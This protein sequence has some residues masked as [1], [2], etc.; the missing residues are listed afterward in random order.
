MKRFLQSRFGLILFHSFVFSLIYNFTFFKKAAG[1]YSESENVFFLI[2]L[3][4]VLFFVI[5]IFFSLFSF[6]TRLFKLWVGFNYIVSAM[7]LYSMYAYNVVVDNVMILNLFDSNKNELL[8]LISVQ[9]I[10]VIF[11]L[12]ITP[13]VFVVFS[14]IQDIGFRRYFVRAIGL[15]CLCIVLIFGNLKTF[16]KS[17]ASFFRKHKSIRSYIL[18]IFPLYSIGKLLSQK[19]KKE[20]PYVD[21]ATDVSQLLDK[22]NILFIVIGE[23]VR[24]DHLSINGY[25]KKTTPKLANENIITYSNVTSC[26]TSTAYSVPCLFSPKNMDEFKLDEFSSYSNLLDILKKLP[27]TKVVWRDN[28]SDSK[29]VAKRIGSTDYRSRKLNPI[30]NEEC[31]D[32]GMLEGIEKLYD[33]ET[34]NLIIVFHLMGSH[35]PSY[36][37][38]YPKEFEKFKPICRT[39]QLEKCSVEEINNVYDNTI[40]Y[41]DYF[42]SLAINKLKGLNENYNKTLVFVSDHGESLGEGGYYLHGYPYRFAPKEQKNAAMILWHGDKSHQSQSNNERYVLNSNLISHDNF[43]HTVLGSIGVQTEHYDRYLDLFYH[44]NSKYHKL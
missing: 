4:L 15:I 20:R 38:R 40:L 32:V 44:H 16:S 8:D 7:A 6:S 41:L 26:G 43:F 11:F 9:S 29:G 23:T 27:Q 18:P 25:E 33:K 19:I 10:L 37:K 30:C 42:L 3:F 36:Y 35:G 13:C 12:G 28:N 14:K 31:R 22:K 2:S 21:K 39:G 24:G 34:K 5:V 17:Y 1:I